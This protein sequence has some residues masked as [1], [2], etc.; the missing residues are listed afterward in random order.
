MKIYLWKNPFPYS[1]VLSFVTYANDEQEAKRL[2]IKG[3]DSIL[4][5]GRGEECF[6]THTQNRK[7]KIISGL[8]L[9]NGSAYD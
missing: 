6:N 5:E 7:L 8:A 2:I 3:L 4:G 1:D 9:W